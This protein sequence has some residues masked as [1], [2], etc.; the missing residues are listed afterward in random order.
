MTWLHALALHSVAGDFTLLS[1]NILVC[2]M[3][4]LSPPNLPGLPGAVSEIM[5]VKPPSTGGGAQ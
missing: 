5:H 1:L 4:I 2:E 3:E